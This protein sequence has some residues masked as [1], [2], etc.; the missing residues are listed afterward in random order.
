MASQINKEKTKK[1][2][3][4]ILEK[5]QS[6]A[7]PHLLN[8]YRSIL[9]QEVSFF[10]RSYV[11]AYFLMLQDQGA[12]GSRPY[13]A[14]R[15]GAG[16]PAPVRERENTSAEAARYPLPEDESTRLFISIGRNR[17]VFPREI[18]G[19][20]NAKTS[21]SKDDI[22]VIRILDNYSFVQVR[23]NV[24]DEIIEALNGK[25][26][27]GRTLA[28]NYAR[29][30]KE[31][32][33]SEAPEDRVFEAASEAEAEPGERVPPEAEDTRDEGQAEGS[34]ATDR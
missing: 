8:A 2:L 23:N 13:K 30:R 14:A 34:I 3:G 32:A 7:D 27:R 10:R 26:F 15:P 12:P 16:S 29:N 22:G 11:A 20:I 1:R 6:E 28:V 33:P 5:I 25:S 19:L 31:D 9:R 24:A 18:L 4:E 17:R 21:V